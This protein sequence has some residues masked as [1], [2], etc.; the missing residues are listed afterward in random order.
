M[1]PCGEDVGLDRCYRQPAEFSVEEVVGETLVLDDQQGRVHQLNPTASFIWKRCD[2]KTSVQQIVNTL[3]EMF[4]VEFD[5]ACRDVTEAIAK[6]RK[7]D[8]LSE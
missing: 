3:T 5:V 2:G 1:N 6:L 8:L 7:L 4:D